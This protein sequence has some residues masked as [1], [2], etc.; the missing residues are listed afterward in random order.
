MLFQSQPCFKTVSLYRYTL[1]QTSGTFYVQLRNIHLSL[2]T[3]VISILS[4][5]PS[6]K[7]GTRKS[8]CFQASSLLFSLKSLIVATQ[9][10]GYDHSCQ[11][12][13]QARKKSSSYS[14]FSAK[15]L[16]RKIDSFRTLIFSKP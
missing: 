11:N 3:K 1:R 9:T 8:L 6:Q 10:E 5:C 16:V 7:S 14:S 13:F 4:K 12:N 15:L 2:K